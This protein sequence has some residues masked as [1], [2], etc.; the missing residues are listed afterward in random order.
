MHQMNFEKYTVR[1]LEINDLEVY[2][3]LVD[4]N[5]KRLE[6]FFTKTVSRTKTVEDTALFL[7]ELIKKSQEKTYYPF[8]VVDIEANVPVGFIDIK[9]IDWAIPKAELGCFMDEKYSGQGITTKVFS[10]F[11]DYCF[12]HFGFEKLCL[13]THHSNKQARQLAEK[14]GFEVE[15]QYEKITKQHQ[16]KL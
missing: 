3:K 8:V 5:R 11:V 13:R 7:N 15:E 14:C 6:D 9:N 1:L 2:F 16:E 12:N 10:L 4:R